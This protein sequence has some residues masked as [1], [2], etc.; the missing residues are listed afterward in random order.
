MPTQRPSTRLLDRSLLVVAAIYLLL[1]IAMTW[2]VVVNL[3]EIAGDGVDLYSHLWTFHWIRDALLNGQNPYFTERIFYPTGV[4]LANHNIAWLQILLWI[5]LQALFGSVPGYNILM[6]GV[7]AANGLALYLLALELLKNRAVAFVCGLIVA[8]WPYVI[9]QNEHPNMMFIAWV[10]LALLFLHRALQPGASHPRCSALLAALFLAL[11]AWVRLQLMVMAVIPVG[12][13]VLSLLWP[14]DWAARKRSGGQLLLIGAATAVL[15]LPVTLP[16]AIHQITRP[17]PQDLFLDEDEEKQTDLLAYITPT[18]QHPLWDS[19]LAPI[20]G[21]FHQNFDVQNQKRAPYLGYSVILLALIGAAAAAR[22]SRAWTVMAVILLLFAL[23]P[24]LRINGQLFPAVPMPYRLV[25][26]NPLVRLLRTPDRMNVLLGIPLSMLA[27]F[28]LLVLRRW[29]Q[30]PFHGHLLLGIVT[31]LILSEY[32]PFPYPQSSAAVP[33]WLA[34]RQNDAD[35]YALLHLPNHLFEDNKFY[36]YYQTVHGKP[37]VNGKVARVPRTALAFWQAVPLLNQLQAESAVQ[38]D[39]ADVSRQLGLLHEAGVRYLVI[40]KPLAEPGQLAAWRDWLTIKSLH[41]DGELSVYTTAPQAGRDFT[42]AQQLTPAVGLIRHS[43]N[44][45]TAVAGGTLKVDLRLGAATAPGQSLHACFALIAADGSESHR[46]CRP[47]TPSWPTETWP[48][49]A[50]AKD[51]HVLWI[52]DTIS[53]NDYTIHMQLADTTNTPLGET[54]VLGP[55]I[56]AP[57]TPTATANVNWRDEISLPDYH[58]Q[59]TAEALNLTLYWQALD[60]IDNQ[61]K[62]FIHLIDPADGEIV[63][64][65]DAAPRNW[66]YPTFAWE[67][68][69][70]VHDTVL[71][72]LA[73]VPPG[74]YDLFVGWYNEETGA[75]LPATTPNGNAAQTAVLLTTV[76]VP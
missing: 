25:A 22:R 7:I 60:D 55:V 2:P 21:R 35:N 3:G 53:P 68:N 11:T 18:Q 71:L 26:E 33:A 12:L 54:A 13:F 63:A 31:L 6:I 16:V 17:N 10:P 23:G 75:R 19:T 44:P 64:Q 48:A 50:V 62:F 24:I 38:I 41:E 46:F 30:R 51:D 70:R 42:I 29:V 14:Q 40:H 15:I 43:I 47:V 32:A 28:G 57:Y 69:E 76:T 58:L 72:T 73:D 36:M 37:I 59:Q 27:G 1:T 34:D 4:S 61:Y 9:T 5:P 39:R 67:P 66:A 8:F 20:Y 49:N 52:D 65:V 74:Q 45:A 56:I